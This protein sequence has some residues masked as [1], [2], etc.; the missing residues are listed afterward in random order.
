MALKVPD[1][2]EK[3][4]DCTDKNQAQIERFDPTIDGSVE[5]VRRVFLD[6]YD[7]LIRHASRRV[8]SS[9]VA[10]DIVQQA[11][12]N[13][14]T[15][16]EQ[17]V[18]VNNMKGFLHRCVHNLCVN[19]T[20]RQPQLS[21]EE[22]ILDMTHDSTEASAELRERWREVSS[23]LGKLAPAARDVFVSAE[24]KGHSSEEIAER[25]DRSVNAV[26]QLLYRA[27]RDI[28]ANVRSGS[29]WAGI[30]IPMVGLARVLDGGPRD[31]QESVIN[32][33][34]AKAAEVNSW[35]G[36]LL[37]RGPD[38]LIQP[39]LAVAASAVIVALATVSSPPLTEITEREI[40]SGAE[41]IQRSDHATLKHSQLTSESPNR[42]ATLIHSAIDKGSSSDTDPKAGRSDPTGG[43]KRTEHRSNGRAKKTNPEAIVADNQSTDQAQPDDASAGPPHEV[44]PRDS[45]THTSPG[46][47]SGPGGGA[48]GPDTETTEIDPPSG[49]GGNPIGLGGEQGDQENGG[50]G[51]GSQP[52]NQ[53]A[54]YVVNESDPES[55]PLQSSSRPALPANRTPNRA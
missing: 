42:D 50:T 48:T 32:W 47:K 30:S 1:V 13:T 46:G 7:E 2:V 29:D 18:Q 4:S 43:S 6:S 27:R 37:Q 26:R 33:L 12:A 16:V 52:E 11:F 15:A 8:R 40:S 36:G 23:A 24:L 10:Q 22:Q 39:Q 31:K 35:L 45:G 55:V 20:L 5:A 17:G 34:K 14:L 38:A 9:D 49:G 28:R 41:H 54:D 19:L 25:M 44:N 51:G 21:I 53:D 3:Q